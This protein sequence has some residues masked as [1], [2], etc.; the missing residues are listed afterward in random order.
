MLVYSI[1]VAT[2][3]PRLILKFAG[4]RVIVPASAPI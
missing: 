1:T 2:A 3:T 4:I